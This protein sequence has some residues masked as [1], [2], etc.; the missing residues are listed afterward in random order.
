MKSKK[1]SPTVR[2]VQISKLSIIE[3]H[4]KRRRSQT[5]PEAE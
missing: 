4:Y 2:Y 5:D 1:V 3:S